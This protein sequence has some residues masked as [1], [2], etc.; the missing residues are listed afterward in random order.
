MVAKRRMSSGGVRVEHLAEHAAQLTSRLEAQDVVGG[1]LVAEAHAVAVHLHE[2]L[3][4][5]VLLEDGTGKR[6][7]SGKAVESPRADAPGESPTI[8]Q[9][10]AAVACRYQL[11]PREGE[12]LT[13]LARGRTSPI[14]QEKLVVSQNT[15]RT[16]VRHIYAKL[17]VHSQQELINLVD[18]AG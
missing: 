13:L 14:I 4:A 5:D 12:V 2:G 15:V 9:R 10:C 6:G 18:S 16:H 7:A 1:G 8:D 3:A 17:N 11:T